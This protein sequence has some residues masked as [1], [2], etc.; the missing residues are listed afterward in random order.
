MVCHKGLSAALLS[1]F[2]LG[3]ILLCAPIGHILSALH[4]THSE[5]P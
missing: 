3:H 5:T 2:G 1:E 4:L